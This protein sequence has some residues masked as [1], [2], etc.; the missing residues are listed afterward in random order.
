APHLAGGHRQLRP[1]AFAGRQRGA[2]PGRAADLAAAAR[3]QLDVVYRHA[4]W[5]AVER[6]AVSRPR[7]RAGPAGHLVAGL[8]AQGRQDV[9]LLAVRVLDQRDPGRTVRVVLDRLHRGGNSVVGIALEVDEAVHLLVSAAAEP[10]GDDALIV[11][12]A[13]LLLGDQQ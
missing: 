11:A 8:Q 3:L 13:S 6:Q 9:A 12:A 4:Q 2:A 5:D 1:V 10:G 7:L